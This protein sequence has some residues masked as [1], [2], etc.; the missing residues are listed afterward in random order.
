MILPEYIEVCPYCHG[1]QRTRQ[2]YTAGCGGGYYQA[3]GPCP[4]CSEENHHWCGHGFVYKE[5]CIPV[6]KSVIEQINSL[7]GTDFKPGS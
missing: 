6:S 7:N 1:K 4:I 3:G 2:T 5:A